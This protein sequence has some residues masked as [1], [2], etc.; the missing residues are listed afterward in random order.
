[1]QNTSKEEKQAEQIAKQLLENPELLDGFNEMLSLLKV[2]NNSI[3]SAD[4]AEMQVI[5]ITRR[6]GKNLL[7]NWA[8][9]KHDLCVEQSKTEDIIKNGK[10]N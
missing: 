1:M 6:L 8:I 7:Q 3:E 4:E 9:E 2:E 10:K 5:E